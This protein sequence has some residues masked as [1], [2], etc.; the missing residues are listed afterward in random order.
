M[1]MDTNSGNVARLTREPLHDSFGR[2][3]R[4]VRISVTDRCNF[5]CV[6]CMPAEGLEWLKREQ[7]L[8]FE[9]IE[10]LT[11]LLVSMGVN[12][13]RLT[14]GE[15]LVRKDLPL[16]ISR[17]SKIEGLK[18]LSLT[19][20]G[21][22]LKDMAKDLAE[23]GLTRINVSCD[24]LIRDKF[25]QITRRDD[26]QRVLQ[27]LEE[28]E[29][30]P[31]ITPIK[32]NAVAMRGFTEEEV[33]P[34][35]LL[36]RRKPYSIRFIEFMPLDADQLWDREMVLTGDELKAIIERDVG[37]LVEI[38]SDDPAETATKYR[39]WDGKGELGFINPVSHPFCRNC[40][41]IRMTAE[42]KMLTCLFGHIE[43]DLKAVLRSGASDEVLAETI[44]RAV[45][46]KELKHFINDGEAFKRTKRN[47]S[48]IGG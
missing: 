28:L 20:N 13:V 14:G 26:L 6:Y 35:A 1:E 32:V 11:R 16:L 21:V 27:G 22:L 31:T 38:P 9:E 30:Y 23:A 46:Q 10:R 41:R 29:K 19:T 48:Q 39:F 44:R 17:L 3:I 8:S 25:H 42:G 43:T 34:F 15:P 37:K 45:L 33:V 36:A 5:R 18:S 7:I 12:Q 47:M 24:S 4:N 40:D 2:F